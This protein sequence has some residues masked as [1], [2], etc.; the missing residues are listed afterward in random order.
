VARH[1]SCPMHFMMFMDSQYLTT[2]TS[3]AQAQLVAASRYLCR[4]ACSL[5]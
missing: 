5:E 2:G 4:V 1:P 3:L